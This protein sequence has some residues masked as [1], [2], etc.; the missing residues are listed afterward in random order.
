[1]DWFI[2]SAFVKITYQKIIESVS[3]FRWI[4]HFPIKIARLFITNT[5][6]SNAKLKLAKNQAKAK[7]HPE[8][9]LLLLENYSLFSSIC[10]HHPSV[11]YSNK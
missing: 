8:I 3:I 2:H 7:Q 5:F 9:E 10:Y 6:T 4:S 1:M 11:T